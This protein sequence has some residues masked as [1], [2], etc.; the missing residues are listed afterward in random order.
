MTRF[1]CPIHIDR[2]DIKIP[3]FEVGDQ[4]RKLCQSIAQEL[5]AIVSN[6]SEQDARPKCG[7]ETLAKSRL[8]QMS[9]SRRQAAI[10]F[11][12]LTAKSTDQRGH[13]ASGRLSNEVRKRFRSLLKRQLVAF[14]PQLINAIKNVFEQAN[15]WPI[16]QVRTNVG[17]RPAGEIPVPAVQYMC[18]PAPEFL[19][20]EWE[21]HEPDAVRAYWE[22][23]GPVENGDP[24]KVIG[25]GYV[26]NQLTAS[27]KIGGTIEIPLANYLPAVAP[28]PSSRYEMRILPLAAQGSLLATGLQSGQPLTPLS[29]LDPQP[30]VGVGPWSFPAVVEYGVVCQ[31]DTPQLA[32]ENYTLFTKARPVVRW[33]RVA[34][35][36]YGNGDEEYH[37]RASMIEQTA[38]GSTAL[39]NFGSYLPRE[40]GDTSRHTLGWKGYRSVLGDGNPNAF[41]PRAYL[42]ILSVLE[43]DGGDDLDD[44]KELIAEAA[45]EALDGDLGSSLQE[46]LADLQKEIDDAAAETEERFSREITGIFVA[47]VAALIS[48]TVLGMVVAYLTAVIGII[49]ALI[50]VGEAD[51]FYGIEVIS[52]ILASNNAD[53]IEDGTAW[54]AQASST[55]SDGGSSTGHYDGGRFFLDDVSVTLQAIPELGVAGNNGIVEFGLTMEFYD[56]VQRS[57]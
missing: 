9:E 52:F 55:F 33:F 6:A 14:R 43:E 13:D 19:A 22:L 16:E 38:L 53:W 29:E 10:G 32:I 30:P 39:G 23:R 1:S 37:I 27:D 45:R 12:K 49:V 17:M 54:S 51:D 42:I 46:F 44:W 15:D 11:A 4:E 5:A 24:G 50:S 34:A 48:S 20:F 56:K 21:S 18:L 28:N 2:P 26:E 7:L 8:D 40:E 3:K 25:F 57:W 31:Q 36:Q 47:Y 41:P 35:D